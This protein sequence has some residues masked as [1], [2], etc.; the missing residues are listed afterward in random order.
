VRQ[1]LALI[2]FAC[3]LVACNSRDVG[4]FAP[5]AQEKSLQQ[6]AVSKLMCRI[7]NQARC[8]HVIENRILLARFYAPKTLGGL[9]E[10]EKF[11]GRSVT[12]KFITEAVAGIQQC[13]R[14]TAESVSLLKGMKLAGGLY[15]LRGTSPLS[16]QTSA[17]FL[18]TFSES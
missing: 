3:V 13:E 4:P 10:S 6:V 16:E 14:V 15:E 7:E 9:D 12:N 1:A 11:Q 5:D 17:C 8:A 2:I 18:T